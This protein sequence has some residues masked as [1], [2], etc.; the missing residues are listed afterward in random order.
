VQVALY[1]PVTHAVTP[2]P[3]LTGAGID[4]HVAGLQDG[5]FILWFDTTAGDIGE[6]RVGANG[7][8]SLDAGIANSFTTGTQ[9]QNAIAANASGTVFF[10][11]QDGGSGNPNSTDMD[12][13][14]EAQ[15]FHL[16]PPTHVITP[17]ER[18]FDSATGD[19]F[20]TPSVAEANQIRATLPTYHDEGA[21]WGTP[22]KGSDT[23]DVFRF[24]DVATGAL[25]DDQHRRAR[26]G[27]LNTALIPF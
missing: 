15:A 10:A 21:P 7:L 23:I 6:L 27:A 3:G 22:D 18:F 19:H 8:T 26:P 16:P 12:T 13:R 14:I 5:G 11:W 9:D 4:P 24:F 17:V 2:L 20:Y 25:P 1:D